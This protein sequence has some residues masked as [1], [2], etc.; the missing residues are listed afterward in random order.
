MTSGNEYFEIY[1]KYEH[2]NKAVL[3][4]GCAPFYRILSYDYDYMKAI[5]QLLNKRVV[6]LY[7]DGCGDLYGC[8]IPYG[9]LEDDTAV[10]INNSYIVVL[11]DGKICSVLPEGG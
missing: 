3:V 1:K 4:S 9:S 10:L 11:C 7:I 2:L 6:P 5:C 8:C